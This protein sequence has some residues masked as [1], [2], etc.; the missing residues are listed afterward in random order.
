MSAETIPIDDA[1]S[2]DAF[3]WFFDKHWSREIPEQM[4]LAI[5]QVLLPRLP[6]GARLLDL[7]CGTGQLAAALDQRGYIV[8]GVDNSEQ[9]LRYARRNAPAVE[10]IRADAR[11][12]NL[13]TSFD[14][15][16]STFDS[17]NHF[18]TLEELSAVFRQARQSL[19]STGW[20]LFDMNVERG[21]LSHW[22]DYFAIVE[23]N[24]V[25]VL[26]GDYDP[27]RK[28]G[29]YDITMFRRRGKTWQRAD[30]TIYERCYEEREIK[31]ELKRAG[32]GELLAF[33]AARDL[34]LVDH[35]GRIFFLARQ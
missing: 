23:K 19:A 33:D 15:I 26:R 31:R 29:E 34:G 14:A 20:F 25:C 21:F 11:S 28:I 9:M 5:E 17:L 16:V 18:L 2:Y 22:R 32:F 3:A 7:C 30:T 35:T 12:F 4:M 10:F 8:T 27:E 6:E 24:E 1:S 13:Q